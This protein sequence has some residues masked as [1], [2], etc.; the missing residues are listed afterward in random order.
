MVH[1]S[2]HSAEWLFLSY[3]SDLPMKGAKN[4]GRNSKILPHPVFVHP[5]TVVPPSNPSVEN[6]QI[7]L[8]LVHPI[9]ISPGCLECLLKLLNFLMTV[10]GLA[11]VGY[12]FYLFVK[13]KDAADTVMLFSPVGSDQDL[14]HI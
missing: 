11:M 3:S 7:H 9:P 1:R 5:S 12:G 4:N 13:Y 8:R 2:L 14:I 6:R 10:A